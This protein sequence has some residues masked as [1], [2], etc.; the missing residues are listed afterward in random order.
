M[1]SVSTILVMVLHDPCH[2]PTSRK[3]V[4]LLVESLFPLHGVII[5]ANAMTIEP[6]NVH[7]GMADYRDISTLYLSG[8]K[9]SLID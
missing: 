5:L 3:E 8:S 6:E 1:E 7:L 4:A 9:S 2:E